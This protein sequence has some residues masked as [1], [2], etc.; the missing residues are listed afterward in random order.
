MITTC[1][2][3]I[4]PCTTSCSCVYACQHVL[5]C[6][7]LFLHAFSPYMCVSAVGETSCVC[8]FYL[9]YLLQESRLS[10]AAPSLHIHSDRPPS[11][12]GGLHVKICG[13]WLYNWVI[14]SW[15]W[16]LLVCM[17]VVYTRSHLFHLSHLF[18]DLSDQLCVL[19]LPAFISWSTCS[20]RA[21]CQQ[22]GSHLTSALS[23]TETST[24]CLS[25]RQ[26]FVLPT[27][28]HQRQSQLKYSA[29]EQ[30]LCHTIKEI[31]LCFFFYKD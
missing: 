28:L 6:L 2:L 5:E 29:V 27:A 10:A 12:P 25:V 22:R 13:H 16:C 11:L 21:G 14:F 3:P 31:Q 24:R 20:R 17:H 23:D 15:R 8:L 26:V 30:I 18:Q 9:V 1:V 4:S 7:F 19:T